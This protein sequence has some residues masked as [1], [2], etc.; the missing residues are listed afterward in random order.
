MYFLIKEQILVIDTRIVKLIEGKIESNGI[1]YSDFFL[2]ELPKSDND[3]MDDDETKNYYKEHFEEYEAKRKT[4]END[5]NIC[6]LI[7]N[8]SF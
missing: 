5:S 8:T 1:Q 2:F 3:K 6:S 7:I 4:G